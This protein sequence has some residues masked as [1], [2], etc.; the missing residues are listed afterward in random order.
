MLVFLGV[1]VGLMV[2][3]WGSGVGPHG[4]R[5]M[6]FGLITLYEESFRLWGPNELRDMVR[7]EVLR[8]LLPVSSDEPPEEETEEDASDERNLW[9]RCED[10]GFRTIDDHR[11]L[12][13]TDEGSIDWSNTDYYCSHCKKP[14]YCL[15]EVYKEDS[16]SPNLVVGQVKLNPLGYICES[17]GCRTLIDEVTMPVGVIG[18]V[19][20][21]GANFFDVLAHFEALRKPKTEP[22]TEPVADAPVEPA[23]AEPVPE[24]HPDPIGTAYAAAGTTD[25]GSS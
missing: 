22:V 11:G 24:Q 10:A 12:R 14:I 20:G 3:F 6:L 4:P 25:S 9:D 21:P 23:P 17:C 5:L 19:I 15:W 13:L 2:L 16:P 1:V 18:P 7:Q 8:Q